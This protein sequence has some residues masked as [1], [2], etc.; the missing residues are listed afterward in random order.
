MKYVIRKNGSV[1]CRDENRNGFWGDVDLLRNFEICV[2][3]VD[4]LKI[5]DRI[6]E[7][8]SAWVD[9]IVEN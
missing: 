4:N 6:A 8:Q 7:R 1:L 5:A 9:L 2:V 3:Y